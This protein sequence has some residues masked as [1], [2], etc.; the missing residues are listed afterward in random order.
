[1]SNYTP[2]EIAELNRSADIERR[3]QNKTRKQI[4]EAM[5]RRGRCR[6]VLEIHQE[7]KQLK[8]ATEWL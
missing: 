8:E 5:L 2:Q 4:D 7:E 1:M 3:K 6:W